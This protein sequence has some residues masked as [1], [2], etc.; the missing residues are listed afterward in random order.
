MMSNLEGVKSILISQTAEKLDIE[1]SSCRGGWFRQTFGLA[2]A[3]S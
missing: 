1:A 3:M 2:E